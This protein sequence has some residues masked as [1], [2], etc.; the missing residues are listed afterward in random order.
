MCLIRQAW[1]SCR[2]AGNEVVRAT[3]SVLRDKRKKGIADE[4]KNET[5]GAYGRPLCFIK[6]NG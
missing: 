5:E 2:K 4:K 1:L 6:S 3:A